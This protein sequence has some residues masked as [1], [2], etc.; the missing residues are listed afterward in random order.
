M[1][2]EI[3]AN[4]YQSAI[5]AQK[6]GADR[7][8]LCSE[9]ALGGITP[10]YGLL[11][12]VVIELSIPIHVLI[13]PRSG[14]FVFSDDEFDIMKEN[15]QLCKKLGVAGIVSGVLFSDNSI[16]IV[17]TRELV[18]ISKPMSFTFHRAFD[19]VS[20]PKENLKELINLGID[21]VL[22][23]GQKEKAE[24]GIE[25]L[26]E[27]QR[28]AKDKIIILAGSGINPVNARIFKDAGLNE[29]HTSA[30]KKIYP[31]NDSYYGKT[32]QTVSDIQTIKDIL[33]AVKDA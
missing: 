13:R 28:L 21:R 14:N 19:E 2:V 29:I 1:F 27:L 4:S 23:S 22:T 24:D 7:I 31:K 11:K 25:L 15:I 18:E 32:V 30:S 12:K 9:L 20:N 16:D 26:S 6:A 8:E 5:N 3:C 33:I 17:R 10:S